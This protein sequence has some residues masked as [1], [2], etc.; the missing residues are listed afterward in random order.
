MIWWFVLTGLWFCWF[1]LVV[2]DCYVV[3]IV[4]V[5]DLVICFVW[6][7]WIGLL[8]DCICLVRLWVCVGI[9]FGVLIFGLLVW[10]LWS[11]VFWWLGFSWFVCCSLRVC[12]WLIVFSYVCFLVWLL[13]GFRFAAC[14]LT[15]GLDVFMCCLVRGGWFVGCDVDWLFNVVWFDIVIVLPRFYISP[16]FLLERIWCWLICCFCLLYCRW[17]VW[18]D[19]IAIDCC[20]LVWW[21][22]LLEFCYVIVRDDLVWVCL[23]VWLNWF[24]L[25]DWL[26]WLRYELFVVIACY[27]D[28]CWVGLFEI[29]FVFIMIVV[30]CLVYLTISVGVWFN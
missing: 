7:S 18:F 4:G 17:V 26:R 28:G 16:D 3:F 10:I 21:C 5:W 11:M 19:C 30:I 8:F 9:W 25:D 14:S 1:G 15:A 13:V 6:L 20:G 27:G 24:V 12:T 29:L 23:Y 2:L 22:G